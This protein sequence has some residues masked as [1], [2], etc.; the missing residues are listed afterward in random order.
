MG[1]G[2][3]GGERESVKPNLIGVFFGMGLFESLKM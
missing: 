1:V 2:G 3:R